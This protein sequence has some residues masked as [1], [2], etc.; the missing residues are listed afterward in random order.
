MDQRLLFDA[1]SPRAAKAFSEG[2]D[3][4]F[5]CIEFLLRFSELPDVT[6]E[7]G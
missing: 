2:R 1:L 7:R 3:H 4:L 5:F 6:M